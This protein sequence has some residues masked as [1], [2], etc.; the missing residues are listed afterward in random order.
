MENS[1]YGKFHLRK[2]PPIN[3]S[4]I[5]QKLRIAQKKIIHAKN[6]AKSISI[7]P[8]NLA[9][10]EQQQ[11]FCS[12]MR[13]SS[14]AYNSKTKNRKYEFSSDSA[15]SPS[16]LQR[17]PLLLEGGTCISLVGKNPILSP[18]PPLTKYWSNFKSR[19]ISRCFS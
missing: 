10:F 13:S 12:R 3:K 8:V 18:P 14:A 6:I 17:Y 15:H 9:T 11:I 5:S 19:L 16:F 7:S 4:V 2:I 1:T